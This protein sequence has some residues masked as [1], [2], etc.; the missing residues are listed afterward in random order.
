MSPPPAR[1]ARLQA[2][3]QGA[4]TDPRGAGAAVGDLG[5]DAV[6]AATP[7]LS[8]VARLD[9][10]NRAYRAR[11]LECFRAEFPALEHALGE[12]L[13]RGFVEA[14]LAACPPTSYTVSRLGA[15]LAD[16]L[17]ASRP[18]AGGDERLDWPDFLVDLARLERLRLEVYDGEGPEDDTPLDADGLLGIS[19]EAFL[20]L[21][22]R[23]VPGLR[24]LS[25]RYPVDDYLLAVR[26]NESPALPEPASRS[27]AVH[28]SEWRV[29]LT[30]LVAGESDLLTGLRAGK[31]VAQALAGTALSEVEARSLLLRRADEGLF[32]ERSC[33]APRDEMH[34]Y[35]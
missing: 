2:W 22:P 28:R 27:L 6:I 9:I 17:E 20:A 1:L 11:L 30:R 33:P 10:Y 23:V 12:E 3:V 31:S 35:P 16:Y 4:V 18:A 34:S 19:P 24:L 13:F 25:T 15:G 29:R 8:G 14:Y 26:R 7:G 32:L 5:A 21:R